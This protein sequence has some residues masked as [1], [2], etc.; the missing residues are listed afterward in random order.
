[1]NETRIW[2]KCHFSDWLNRCRSIDKWDESL[3]GMRYCDWTIHRKL[4][5]AAGLHYR[6]I[7]PAR[8]SGKSLFWDSFDDS[9]RIF[10]KHRESRKPTEELVTIKDGDIERWLLEESSRR[11]ADEIYAKI[12]G[13]DSRETIR[14]DTFNPYGRYEDYWLD[15]CWTI[16]PDGSMTFR[17]VSL[18]PGYLL[19][20]EDKE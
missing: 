4:G 5:E 10:K 14:L 6:Y 20:K 3:Q 15:P 18:M 8:G 13:H 16:K 1:M 12:C 7:V 2:H 9:N 19:D 11:W 17:E